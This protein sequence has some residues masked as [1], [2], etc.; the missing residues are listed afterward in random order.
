MDC[1]KKKN[2]LQLILFVNE[3]T[4]INV[5]I[6][7]VKI[8]GTNYF[9]NSNLQSQIHAQGNFMFKNKFY[10]ILCVL[11]S[12]ILFSGCSEEQ[13]AEDKPAVVKTQRLK[14][15]PINQ[16]ENYSGVVKG[17]YET[18]LAFQVG[19]QVMS[20]QIEVGDFVRA[21][22]T[23]MTINPKDVVQQVNQTEAQIASAK[24]QLD[25]AKTNL[26]RYREL[27]Q[28]EAISASTLDQYQTNYDAAVA[29]YESALAA[30]AQS[31]NALD[32]TYLKSDFD[33]VIS[34]IYAENGQ[35][36]AAGQTVATL[37]Q[38]DNLEIAVD[39]PENKIALIEI[40]QPVTVTFWALPD[41]VDGYVREIAPMADSAARTFAIKVSV[42]NPP[43]KMQLGMTASISLKMPDASEDQLFTLPLSAIYQ[44]D[45]QTKVWIVKDG[46][47][48]LKSVTVEK[49]E[50]NDVMVRGLDKNDIVVTAGVHKLHEGQKVSLM[51]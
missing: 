9:F 5:K 38:T 22:E 19:G 35:V 28:S 10:V 46:Q 51:D 17:R 44:T 36:V 26:D 25:L 50:N 27:F 23:L 16:E 20:R 14:S 21:G 24:A 13:A 40:N 33:G 15:N 1:P 2:G 11:A 6:V 31:Q 30:A 29:S 4:S 48:N 34:S 49:F 43:D 7:C 41:K 39:V 45:S 42:P 37:V 47:V 12:M 18:N 8:L 32:Y 3:T